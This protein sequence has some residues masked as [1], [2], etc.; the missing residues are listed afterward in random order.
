M[1][2]TVPASNVII[3]LQHYAHINYMQICSILQLA[4]DAA[5]A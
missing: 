4:D 3:Q 2:A 1:I 5:T